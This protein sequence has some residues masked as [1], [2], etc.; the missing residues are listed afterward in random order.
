M[1]ATD[2]A[3]N[4]LPVTRKHTNSLTRTYGSISDLCFMN[5]AVQQPHSYQ[6]TRDLLV[7]FKHSFS[8][9]FLDPLTNFCNFKSQHTY[10]C[11][12]FIQFQNGKSIS[13][14]VTSENLTPLMFFF[15][16]IGKCFE[17]FRNL[18]FLIICN[19]T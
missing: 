6:L 2:M 10:C 13:H 17:T 11:F 5:L 18:M 9:M 1:K 4:I 3:T 12:K 19:T 15:F 8:S 16:I 7:N 14:A